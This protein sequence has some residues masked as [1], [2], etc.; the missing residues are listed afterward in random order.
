M[1]LKKRFTLKALMMLYSALCKFLLKCVAVE[2]WRRSMCCHKTQNAVTQLYMLNS[3]PN[4]MFAALNT[5][6][7]QFG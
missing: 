4:F 3:A 2:A 5:L 6:T 7:W 1:K